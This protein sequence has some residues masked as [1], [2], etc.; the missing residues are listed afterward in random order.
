M[1]K[2]LP[3][4]AILLCAL[5]GAAFAA[6][7]TEIP[8]NES[9]IGTLRSFEKAAIFEFVTGGDHDSGFTEKNI[10]EF[11]WY[12]LAGDGRYELALTQNTGPCCVALILYW[13]DAPGKVR[14]QSF[15]QAGDLNKTIRD[16]NGD[17]K[18]E[19]IISKLVVENPGPLR[20]YWPAVY[21]LENGNYVEASRDFASFYDNEILPQL[22]KEISKAQAEIARGK[23]NSED[24]LAGLTME[25]D[26]ILRMLGRNPTAGLE[27]A[28]QW[29]NSDNPN[30]LQ[31]A[32]VTFKEIGGHEKEERAADQ[33]KTNAWCKQHPELSGCRN[34]AQH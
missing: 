29:M 27:R 25:Q 32:S 34:A 23:Q 7:I 15:Q 12:D 28:Y 14:S 2:S 11:G 17:G 22:A 21:R 4:A 9:N 20:F 1:K 26:K 31:D 8:W 16:L 6:G 24:T 13:Q 10:W 18:D 30:L 19:L 3:I 5:V 33:A